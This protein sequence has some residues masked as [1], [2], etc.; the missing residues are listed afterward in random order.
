MLDEVKKQKIIALIQRST[1]LNAQ[2]KSDWLALL[3]L[4]NDKQIAELE[5]ILQPEAVANAAAKSAPINS[6][7]AQTTR[8]EQPSL[9]HISNLPT[10]LS[11]P[12]LAPKTVPEQPSKP[13]PSISSSVPYASKPIYPAP[14]KSS[15]G[16]VPTSKNPIITPRPAGNAVSSSLGKD[17]M[18]A[19]P[20]TGLEKLEDV[21]TLT[22]GALHSTNREELYAAITKL[23]ATSGYFA[24][25][26][27]FEESPLYKNYIDYGKAKLSGSTSQTRISQEEFEFITDLL[28]SLKINRV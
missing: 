20:F 18:L 2:E 15:P 1:I 28:L 11:D 24:V 16:F 12:R 23:V 5:E 7:G 10:R 26:T 19:K 21:K 9:S 25:L 6:S 3:D 4:M 13:V 8:M 17:M 22:A 27:N 14:T